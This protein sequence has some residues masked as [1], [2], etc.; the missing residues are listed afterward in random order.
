MKPASKITRSAMLLAL[1]LVF[2][3]LRLLPFIG[4]LPYSAL[5]VGSLV[6]MC[7]YLSVL[8]MDEPAGGLLISVC[9]PVVAFFQGH[10]AFVCLIPFVAVGNA[11]LVLFFYFLQK[12][13]KYAA[14]VVSSAAKWAV[15]FFG[16]K[17]L[18]HFF[19]HV[20]YDKLK[21]IIA[22]FNMPQ[23]ITAVIGGILGLI[24]FKLLPAS[25][26]NTNR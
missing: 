12:V 6:N 26:K 16:S 14:V 15:M 22:G 5:I 18:L 24:V 13:N 4:E 17:Y 9:A 8:T 2:Q 10:L 25:I 21:I 23:L 7:L 3:S 11:V 1:T 19:L 20:D